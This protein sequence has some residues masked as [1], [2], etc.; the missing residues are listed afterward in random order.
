MNNTRKFVNN[1]LYIYRQL[2]GN[3]N[4]TNI[5]ND[6]QKQQL[7][8]LYIY[9]AVLVSIIIMILGGYALYRK[10]IEKKAL[11][12]MEREY[13]LMLR[14]LMN[15]NS[16]QANSFQN[17]RRPH[18]Y[19]HNNIRNNDNDLGSQNSSLEIN[20]EE[21]MENIRRK[22]GNSL[23][24]K[25]LLKKQIEEIPYKKIHEVYGDICTI[26]MEKFIENILISK[27]PC[28]HIFHK[29]C[30]DKYLKGIQKKDKLLCPNCNQ[31]LLINKRFLKLRKKT[32]RIEV[33]KNIIV[34]KNQESEINGENEIKN[35]ASIMTNKNEENA[36]N[37]IKNTE[38]I[39][40]KKKGKKKKKEKK[41][42]I[43][44]I[45]FLNGNNENDIYNPLQIK[46][47]KEDYENSKI[48][49][50]T[51]LPLRE[52]KISENK[53]NKEINKLKRRSIGLV[54][55]FNKKIIIESNSNIF[56]KRK[57]N[58]SDAGSE[59]DCIVVSK[60]TNA[61]LMSSSKQENNV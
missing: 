33:K 9:I 6:I 21:R 39:Y 54:N 4:Q 53:G 22:F 34:K 25:C 60:K 45:D 55:I 16:S 10:C 36:N 18:S 42:K 48:E 50:D 17:E 24:I 19:S 56:N 26:C 46:L 47:K 49:K 38:I 13:Q 40:I 2:Q 59:R 41:E 3:T 61:P 32:N 28:E 14:N 23:M 31:N 57:I 35:Q 5:S 8:D 20:H 1:I 51:V 43:N 12:E 58:A 27:T 7:R 44:N 11:E 15:S 52:S 29:I 30:F 37:N